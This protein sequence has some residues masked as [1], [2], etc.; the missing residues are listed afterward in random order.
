MIRCL[1]GAGARTRR[2]P[3]GPVGR[4]LLYGNADR[5]MKDDIA[6]QHEV[7]EQVRQGQTSS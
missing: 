3:L 4:P 6:Y 2:L 5:G 7:A 1:L